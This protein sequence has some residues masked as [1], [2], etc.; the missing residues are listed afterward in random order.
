MFFRLYQV[1]Y[2]V[3]VL[4]SQLRHNLSI[5]QSYN[6][7]GEQRYV[8]YLKA[9]ALLAHKTNISV[10]ITFKNLFSSKDNQPKWYS[11]VFL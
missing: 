11:S 8:Q 5:A 10:L 4:N 3:Q 1:G 2:K 9:R 7:M 6:P